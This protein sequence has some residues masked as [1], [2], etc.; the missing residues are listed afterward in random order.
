MFEI[1]YL[2]IYIYIMSPISIDE[3]FKLI[4]KF[5]S[6]IYSLTNIVKYNDYSSIYITDNTLTYLLNK[7]RI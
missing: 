4:I 3:L 1:K 7:Y 2:F 6:K 5:S